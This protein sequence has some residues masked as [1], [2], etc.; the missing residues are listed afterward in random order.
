[1]DTANKKTKMA[2]ITYAVM[3]VMIGLDQYTKQM[4]INTMPIEVFVDT[5]KYTSHAPYQFLPW[6]WFNHVVNFGAAWSIFYGKTYLLLIIVA[7]IY[8][9]LIYYEFNS[10]SKRTKTFSAGI[11][12]ILG[13]LG[14]FIDRARMGYVTDFFDLRNSAGQN[15]FPIFNVADIS[16]DIGIACLIFYVLFQEGKMEKKEVLNEEN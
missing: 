4:A 1:M 12:F 8:A 9:G 13:G 10:R 2:V 14:N 6:L 7:S 15:V 3:I 5:Q 11:G 16:I